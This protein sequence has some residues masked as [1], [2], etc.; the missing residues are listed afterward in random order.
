MS[1]VRSVTLLSI[2]GQE[3][4]L[5]KRLHGNDD[6]QSGPEC[7]AG[8]KNRFYLPAGKAELRIAG[9]LIPQLHSAH[10]NIKY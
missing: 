8:G 10:Q 2:R 1:N 6:K 9:T 7:Q 3:I 5:T 4:C